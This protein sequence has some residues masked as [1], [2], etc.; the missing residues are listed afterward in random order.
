M[1]ACGESKRFSTEAA[2]R[3]RL[4]AFLRSL[5]LLQRIRLLFG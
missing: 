4:R 5:S 2:G 3:V 1:Q